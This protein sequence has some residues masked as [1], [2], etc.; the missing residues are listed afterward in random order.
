MSWNKHRRKASTRPVNYVPYLAWCPEH[1]KKVF[2]KRNA[3][4][5]IGQLHDPGMR[6]YRC[7]YYMVEGWHV[8]HLPGSVRRGEVSADEV[9][10]QQENRWTTSES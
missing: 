1:E 4:K 3:K 7:D 10:E 2:T 5:L 6:R 8:G 9:Y